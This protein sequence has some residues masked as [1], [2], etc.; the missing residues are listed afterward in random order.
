MSILSQ[1]TT[2]DDVQEE[3]DTLGGGSFLTESG[4]YKATVEIAYISVAKSGAM[5]LNF[6][7]KLDNGTLVRRTEYFTSGDAKGKKTYYEKDGKKFN[8]P[9]FT[10]IND[11]CLLGVEK[12]LGQLDTED[13]VIKLYDFDAKKEM[14]KSVPCIVDLH[15]ATVIAGVIKQTVDKNVKQGDQYVPSGETRDEN[16]VEKFFYAEDGRTVAEIK[17]KA[18]EGEFLGKWKEKNT[19]VT[20]NKAKG[21]KDGVQ[22]GAPA[23]A[24]TKS[25]FG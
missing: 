9:G 21:A 24:P 7:L 25:L 20:R 4:A 14:P 6:H 8:L 2:A 16:I 22:S 19:G 5:A 1:I 10:L 3:K 13:K 15:G 11:L 18:E 12:G 23:A 17:A